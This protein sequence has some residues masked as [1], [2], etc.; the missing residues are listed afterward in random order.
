MSATDDAIGIIATERDRTISRDTAVDV[1]SK[2]IPLAQPME[3]LNAMRSEGWAVACH[4]DY[5][6][7]GDPHTFWLFTHSH[8]GWVRGEGVTDLEA[9][10]KAHIDATTARSIHARRIA[11]VHHEQWRV[12]QWRKQLVGQLGS[13]GI[14]VCLNSRDGDRMGQI[15]GIE[16]AVVLWAGDPPNDGVQH[17]DTKDYDQIARSKAQMRA[18]L[19]IEP[20]L[21]IN[22]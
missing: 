15:M 7:A 11:I 17:Y 13:Q 8:Y 4:N 6:L 18:M 2:L 22:I 14:A 1:M 9:L 19:R 21:W 5:F 20:S 3:I 12:D 16:F 10:K